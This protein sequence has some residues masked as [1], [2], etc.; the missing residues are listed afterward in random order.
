MTKEMFGK[1]KEILK[2]DDDHEGLMKWAGWY[3][4]KK[5]EVRRRSRS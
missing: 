2:W 3:G 1:V 5:E 4:F